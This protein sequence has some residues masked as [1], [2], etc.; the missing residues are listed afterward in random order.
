L[1]ESYEECVRGHGYPHQ[2]GQN[3]HV[4]KGHHNPPLPGQ[5]ELPLFVPIT[6]EEGDLP[7]CQYVEGQH[8]EGD[9]I[10]ARKDPQYMAFHNIMTILRTVE[11]RLVIIL[12]CM[13]RN[14]SQSCC[15]KLTHGP[16]RYFPEFEAGLGKSLDE[17]RCNYIDF[18]FTSA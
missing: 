6:E 12:T 5:Y 10:L 3:R 11:G 4:A 18:L 8:I 2:G 13:P 7:I 17:F 9:L 1:M 14:L 16:N 15:H